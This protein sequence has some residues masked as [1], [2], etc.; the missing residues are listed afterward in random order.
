M[1]DLIRFPKQASHEPRAGALVLHVAGAGVVLL[2]DDV[3]LEL[4]PE[5]ARELAGDLV[6]LA[7]DA[8]GVN[9]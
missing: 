1:G 8:E 6:E 5:Q 3:E 4:T 2:A 9:A 7:A